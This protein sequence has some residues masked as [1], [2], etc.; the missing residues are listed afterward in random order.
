[1]MTKDN[2]KSIES[3]IWDAA[4]ST[5]G[6]AGLLIKCELTL[7]EKMHPR[8]KKKYA[9]A[10]LYGQEYEP[11]S[12]AMA[13]MNMIIKEE[14]KYSRVVGTAEIAKNDYNISPSRYIHTGAADE[15]RPLS[16]IVEE[17]NDLEKEARVTDKALKEI[18]AGLGVG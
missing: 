17:L 2:G 3:W 15:Y 9:P 5:C 6:S 11:S 13:N 14:E 4:C 12:W 16:E 18:L 8:S 7:D 1:M 10:K